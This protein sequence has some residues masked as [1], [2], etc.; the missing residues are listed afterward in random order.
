VSAAVLVAGCSGGGGHAQSWVAVP[1]V[2][3]QTQAGALRAL[4][5]DHLVPKVLGV[6]YF[7]MGTVGRVIAQTPGAGRNVPSGSTVR[8]AVLL[9]GPGGGTGPVGAPTNSTRLPV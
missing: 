4:A 7:G 5:A 1:N 8:V 2:L 6:R 9:P 3:A